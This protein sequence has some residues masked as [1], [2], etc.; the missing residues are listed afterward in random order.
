MGSS[1]PA[2]EDRFLE[3]AGWQ[4]H[5]SPRNDYDLRFGSVLPQSRDIQGVVV[6]LPGLSEFGEKYF[7]V[8]RDCLSRNLAFWVIDWRG[9]GQSGR[10]LS[11]PDKRHG[12]DFKN[13]ADDLHH[14]IQD[15]V[16][17][18]HP[19][20]PLIM[21]AHSMGANIGLRYLY[22]YPETFKCAAFSAPMIGIHAVRALPRWFAL[23][24]SDALN[25]LIGEVFSSFHG[26]HSSQQ[27][28]RFE[29]NPLTSDPVRFK[30]MNAWMAHDNGLR[31]GDVTFGWVY[32]ALRSC[33]YVQ[34]IAEDIKTPCLFA[35]AEHE[36]IVDND[37]AR[38]AI[39]TVPDAKLIELNSA[40]HEILMEQD[41]IR[42]E[43]FAF[44]D[45]FISNHL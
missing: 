40:Q 26:Q 1:L 15:F 45:E 19:K 28:E 11:N 9:Q 30:V 34:N 5:V 31:V 22:D 33:F 24:L 39:A 17:Q 43:F 14:L 13:Y 4:W 38:K 12:S 37:A 35:L 42:A 27:N 25:T 2:L 3:P 21:L 36:T 10:Y 41:F 7:E 23:A 6:C 16:Q 44:F 8:A 18:R 32:H 29:H 20:Q